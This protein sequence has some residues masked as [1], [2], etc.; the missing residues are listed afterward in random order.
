ML[1]IKIKVYYSTYMNAMRID[2]EDNEYASGPTKN[3]IDFNSGNS[4]LE[5]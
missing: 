3:I 1:I 2:S 5:N 4:N